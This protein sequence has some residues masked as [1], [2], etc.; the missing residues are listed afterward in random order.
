MKPK[1]QK[2]LAE[3]IRVFIRLSIPT[4]DNYIANDLLSLILY[5]SIEGYNTRLLYVG[6]FRIESSALVYI[7]VLTFLIFETYFNENLTNITFVESLPMGVVFCC[8]VLKLI[9]F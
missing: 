7:A 4:P 9:A 3:G 2:F 1:L 8:L 5:I 6:G